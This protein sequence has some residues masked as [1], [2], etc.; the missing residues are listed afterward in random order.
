MRGFLYLEY[1]Y[2]FLAAKA[3]CLGGLGSNRA[4]II[5]IPLRSTENNA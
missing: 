3:G 5:A 2:Y 1:C 4:L